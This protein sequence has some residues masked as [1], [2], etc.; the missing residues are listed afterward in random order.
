MLA[1]RPQGRSIDQFLAEDGRQGGGIGKVEIAEAGDRN[2]QLHGIGVIRTPYKVE[3][4][5]QPVEKETDDFIIVVNEEYREGLRELEN[6]KCITNVFN[7]LRSGAKRAFLQDANSLIMRT[8]NLIE[9]IKHLK[10]TF[11]SLER[12]TSYARA[13]T[14]SQKTVK[15]LKELR[16]A[17]LSR[18]HVGL[19]TG[20]D[21]LLKNVTKGVTSEE[22]I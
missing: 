20:D 12:I 15:E 6:F 13:K 7:W 9:V 19:E 11:S 10:Q 17:G 4:P 1:P 2:V 18:L 8:H 21:E 3:A 22:H 14:L 5:R 16:K